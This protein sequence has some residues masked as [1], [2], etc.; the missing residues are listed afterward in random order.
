M[1]L[2]QVVISDGHIIVSIH[3]HIIKI[4]YQLYLIFYNHYLIY[5]NIDYIKSVYLYFIF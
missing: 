2:T 1:T 4:I 5:I 3:I